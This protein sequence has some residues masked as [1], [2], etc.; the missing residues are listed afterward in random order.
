MDTTGSCTTSPNDGAAG[1]VR[2]VTFKEV[3]EKANDV[4]FEK[5]NLSN[6]TSYGPTSTNR[7]VHMPTSS[8]AQHR[9]EYTHKTHALCTQAPTR[10]HI[11]AWTYSLMGPCPTPQKYAHSQAQRPSPVL[12]HVF[13]EVTLGTSQLWTVTRLPSFLDTDDQRLH[14]CLPMI[15]NRDHLPREKPAGPADGVWLVPGALPPVLPKAP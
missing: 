10:L 9:H 8:S 11:R 12:A 13:W 3:T 14:W 15:P 5:K 7:G 6:D 4:A 1:S 2:C